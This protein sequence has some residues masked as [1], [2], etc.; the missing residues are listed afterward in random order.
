MTTETESEPI[1]NKGTALL[2]DETT[3]IHFAPR[4]GRKNLQGED[5][6]RP[7]MVVSFAAEMTRFE[8]KLNRLG[9]LYQKTGEVRLWLEFVEQLDHGLARKGLTESDPRPR[10]TDPLGTFPRNG[11][12]TAAAHDV[13]GQE[14]D[15]VEGKEP[16]PIT[17]RRKKARTT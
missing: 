8:G 7:E 15:K 16:E 13:L 3:L 2:I 1:L 14:Q 10:I 6:T 12:D 5:L 9:G 17:Q 4:R 11:A